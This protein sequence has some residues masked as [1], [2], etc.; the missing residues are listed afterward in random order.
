MLRDLVKDR[1]PD[2]LFL[3]KMISTANKIESLRIQMGFSQCF[4]VDRV[5]NSGGCSV[6]ERPR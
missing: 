6:L 3:S 2:V 5:G 1:K 4:A